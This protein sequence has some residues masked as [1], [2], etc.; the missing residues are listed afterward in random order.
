MVFRN[1]WKTI[2]Y[3]FLTNVFVH[4]KAVLRVYGR[5]S[6]VSKGNFVEVFPQVPT[7]WLVISAFNEV[8]RVA[9]GNISMVQTPARKSRFTELIVGRQ[10]E[11]DKMPIT[12]IG[13][14]AVRVSLWLTGYSRAPAEAT[15][16][17]NVVQGTCHT[18]RLCENEYLDIIETCPN[19]EFMELRWI[20]I[21]HE[22][23]FWWLEK[24]VQLE[25][26]SGGL[27]S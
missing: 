13:P 12:S 7:G 15:E 20:M 21:A 27:R 5:A 25:R 24:E 1:L 19:L 3:A 14:I 10:T 6:T 8:L 17:V 22:S 26:L 2:H 4:G 11:G 23:P 16:I 9:N 18:Q